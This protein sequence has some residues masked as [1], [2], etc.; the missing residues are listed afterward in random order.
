MGALAAAQGT[1]ATAAVGLVGAWRWVL[2]R[3]LLSE[4]GYGL[5]TNTYT[6]NRT[7]THRHTYIHTL[8]H[9]HT[10][11]TQKYHPHTL[12]ITYK[13]RGAYILIYYI[14]YI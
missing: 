1:L 10:H 5:L 2:A 8:T 9:S 7:D 11:T 12:T 13:E 14:Y 4:I 6:D 3:A